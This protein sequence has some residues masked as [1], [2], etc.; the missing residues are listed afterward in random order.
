MMEKVQRFGSAMLAPV[1]LFAFAGL[2]VGIAI[3][4]QNGDLIPLAADKNSPWNHFWSVWESG[5]WTVFNQ[6][7]LLFVIGLPIALAKTANARAV[8]EAAMVY[9]TFNYFVGTMLKVWGKGEGGTGFFDLDYTTDI[10]ESAAGTGLKMIAGIKTMDTGIFGAIIISAIVVWVH[11]RWFD[12]KL[13]DFLGIF[14]GS[15]YVYGVCFFL[16]M[17]VAFLFS[18]LWPYAQHGISSLQGFF[19]ASGAIGVW[20]YTFLERFLI[21]TGLHHFIYSPFVFGNVVTPNGIAKDWPSHLS[22][23]AKSDKPLKELFPGGGFALHGNSKVFAPIGIAAAFYTTARPE[24]RKEVL[25]LL[26]PV[27][28]TAILIGITEPLEFTFLFLAPPLFL[29]HAILAATMAAIM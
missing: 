26:I 10:S 22:E 29:V 8:M 28:L 4:A 12:K 17:P 25:A 20:V 27:S 15:Q 18:W 23:F 14:Q 2:A 1:L 7:E 16:M 6:M 19:I 11:N 3:I 5:A 21:P 9:L 13:P 24:K